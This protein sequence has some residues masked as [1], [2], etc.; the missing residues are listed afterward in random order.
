MTDK[1]IDFNEFVASVAAENQ[2]FV[3]DLHE[4]LI[5]LGCKIEIKLQKAVIWFLTYITRERLQ[6][7]CFGGKGCLC[8]F[9]ESM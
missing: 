3:R 1:K 6:I 9:M 2:D 8:G 4:S 7:M 5:G